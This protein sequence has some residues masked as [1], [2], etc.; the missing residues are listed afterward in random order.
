METTVDPE[1]IRAAMIDLVVECWRFQKLVGKALDKMD[2]GDAARFVNVAVASDL[3]P[4]T[5]K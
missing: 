1:K 5:T 4:R 3:T 2:H